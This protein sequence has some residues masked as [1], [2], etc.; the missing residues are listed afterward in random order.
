MRKIIVNFLVLICVFMIGSGVTYIILEDPFNN[1]KATVENPVD[2]DG[3]NTSNTGNNKGTYTG[4]ST[5]IVNNTG[6]SESVEKI[7]NAVVL[8]ENYKNGRLAGTGSGFVYKKDSKYGYIMTNQHVVEGATKVV[9]L[10]ANEKK[11]DATVLG[12][13]EYLDIAVLRVPVE[14]ILSVASIGSTEELKLGEAVFAIGS[15][16]GEEYFNSITSG[17]ISGMNRKVTVSVKATSDWIQEV[18]QVDAAINPGNS[19]GPLVNF[20]GE[21]IGV[22]SLKLVDSSVESMGFSIKIEDAMKH[23]K[24]L[25]AGKKIERPLLGINHI[26]ATDTYALARSGIT[27]DK[28]IDYGIV[29]VDIVEGSGASKSDLK[30]GDVIIKIGDNKVTNS[31]NLKYLLYKYTVGDKINLTY[32]RNGKNMVAE[33][34]LT[35]S[36]D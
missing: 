36:G 17:I 10:F 32:I 8:V 27:L 31:A 28:S 7:Y 2:N 3:N 16:V 9:L 20:N 26:N 5:L 29:V 1:E 18:L 21:V 24:D 11:V 23:V 33:V 22:N 4:P 14:N 34:T 13:D 19:G 6:I 12:G 25:E 15:P 35:S 30:K